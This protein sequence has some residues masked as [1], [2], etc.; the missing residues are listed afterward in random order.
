LKEQTKM[1]ILFITAP[2]YDY[3]ADSLLI[4]LREVY[5]ADCIDFP[6]KPIM[7]GE[8]PSLYGRGFTIWSK[9]IADIPRNA[10][11]F[12]DIDVVIYSNYRRQKGIDWRLLVKNKIKAPRVVYVDGNDDTHVEPDL[13]PLFKRELIKP[14]DGVYPIGFGIPSH[15]IRPLDARARSQLHQAHVQDTDFTSETA[16]KFTEEKAYYDDLAKSFFGMTMKKG[17]W[18]CMRHYELLAAGTVVMFKRLDLKPALCAPQCPDF[19]SYSGK[20]DF[21]QKTEA[22]VLNGRPTGE[23]E[24]I[25][26]AQRDWLLA[27]ATCAAR[28]RQLMEQ[29]EKHFAGKPHEPMPQVPFKILRR[30]AM[31]SYMFREN[32]K[33]RAITFVKQNPTV[34]WFYYKVFKKIPGISWFVSRVLMKEK[35]EPAPLQK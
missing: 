29:I 34:D 30:A 17:G 2:L 8:F 12:E 27:N 5:G 22:L 16:Y 15:L 14:Q 18:D 32:S 33:L 7:Y 24:R 25:Q 1:K 6:R 21:L 4:G 20:Q 11:C 10:Q 31:R 23:Y 26:R 13:R 28:A 9:P 19:I 35:H 3:L